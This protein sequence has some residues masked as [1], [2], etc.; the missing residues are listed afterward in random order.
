[1][2]QL[3][4]ECS[5]KVGSIALFQEDQLL[6][7]QPL[8]DGRGNLETLAPAIAALLNR[9]KPDFLS[10]VNGPGSFTSL[11]VGLAQAKMLAFAWDIPVVPVNTLELLAT[12]ASIALH[13]EAA[14]LVLPCLNAYRKQVFVAA[15]RFDGTEIVELQA[16]VVRDAAAWQADPIRE[17]LDDAGSDIDVPI[18]AYCVGPGLEVYPV[19]GTNAEPLNSKYWEPTALNMGDI[20]LAKYRRG[21]SLAAGELLPNYVRRSAAEEKLGG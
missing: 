2:L 17:T 19:A 10:I 14:C 1:M 16:S 12:S 15:Y 21:Q 7:F 6:E 13:S 20:G 8:E 4:I 9:R 5:G 18:K 3:A 11:R